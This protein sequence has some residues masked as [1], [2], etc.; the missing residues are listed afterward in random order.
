MRYYGTCPID[1][2]AV[3]VFLSMKVMATLHVSEL[4]YPFDPDSY[5]PLTTGGLALDQT[6]ALGEAVAW[7]P[8]SSTA[9]WQVCEIWSCLTSGDLCRVGSA[10]PMVL[11]HQEGPYEKS[12]HCVPTKFIQTPRYSKTMVYCMPLEC[13]AIS[14]KKSCNKINRH[15]I[16]TVHANKKSQ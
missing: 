15:Y 10:A 16:P 2:C 6:P 11:H 3:Y 13:F 5:K 8:L 4:I 14:N 9:A 7:C 12:N 1:I